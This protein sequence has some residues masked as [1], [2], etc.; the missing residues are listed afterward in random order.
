MSQNNSIIEKFCKFIFIFSNIDTVFIDSASNLKFEFGYTQVPEPLKQ[1]FGTVQDMLNLS[2]VFSE[3]N[4]AFISTPYKLNFIY[5]KIYDSSEY[6][7][8]IIIGPY[9]IE[10]PTPIILQDVLFENKLPISLR[11]ALTQYYLSLPLISTYKAKSIAEF[12]TYFSSDLNFIKTQTS[13]IGNVTYTS[14]SEQHD[15]LNTGNKNNEIP[16]DL[17][18]KRY[19]TENEFMHAVENGD[20]EKVN[21]LFTEDFLLFNSIPDRIPNDPLR[22]RKNLGFVLNTLLRTAAKRGGLS[23]TYIHSLSEKFAIQIEKASSIQQIIDLQKDMLLGY[24]DAVRKFALKN[25]SY[26][27]RKAIEFIRANLNQDLSLNAISDAIGTSSFEL[28][29]QFKKE[30]GEGI[31]EYINKQRINEAIYLMDSDNISIT[32]IAYMVGFNDVNY[33]TKVFKKI[34]GVT[35]SEYRKN[36]T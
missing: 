12:L 28:S 21:K 7:G 18:E 2:E 20:K 16:M 23:P 6:V 34:K 31:T 27:I 25:F 3:Y 26:S 32:D 8:N 14:K 15:I 29:R 17:I 30:T 19:R 22:S 11:H 5:A 33:F 24:S 10:E 36:N 4:T 1:Y 13:N 9:L 35:P